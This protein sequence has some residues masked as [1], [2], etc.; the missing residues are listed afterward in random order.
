MPAATWER[1][2]ERQRM[3]TEGARKVWKGAEWTGR[4]LKPS[5]YWPPCDLDGTRTV[6]VLQGN[7]G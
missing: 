7:I 3:R 4:I 1:P 2:R 5:I 6:I